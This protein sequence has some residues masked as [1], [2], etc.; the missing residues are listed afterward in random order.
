MDN[1][2]A[3]PLIRSSIALAE[4]VASMSRVLVEISKVA[5]LSS[6]GL[7]LSEFVV[8]VELDRANDLT[9][10][11]LAKRIGVTAQRMNQVVSELL[12]EGLAETRKDAEDSRKRFIRLT[13]L[14]RDRI[15]TVMQDL[16]EF[17]KLEL[18]RDEA[19]LHS[20]SK[21]IARIARALAERK[22]MA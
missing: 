3:A 19:S 16:D 10:G 6:N 15:V 14:G 17:L 21:R 2:D 8:L 9:N 22:E 4:L 1:V 11:R 20:L 7:G 18:S 13:D 5:S 12:K